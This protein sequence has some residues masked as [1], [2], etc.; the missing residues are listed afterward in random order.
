MN[1]PNDRI[2]IS[3][4]VVPDLDLMMDELR[5]VLTSGQL[6]NGR[7]V[8]R[9]EDLVREY[10]GSDLHVVAVSSNTSGMILSW[11]ALEVS[12]EVILPAFT[13]PATAHVIR[14]NGL[15]PVLADCDPETFNLDLA[16]VERVVTERT[17]GVAPVYIFGNAP[18]WDAFEPFLAERGLAAVSD[19]AHAFGTRVGSRPAGSFGS[20]EVFS[21]APT[22]VLTT[23]E[24]GLCITRDGDLADRLRRMRNYGN[25][26]DYDCREL[27]LN[28]RMTEI[29]ALLGVH[30]M[31]GHEAQVRHREQ[32]AALYRERL[33]EIPGI[34]FQRIAP[35]VRCTYNYFALL[36]DPDL[37]G[38]T[39]HTLH[40]LLGQVGIESKI[41][42]HPP[43]HEQR[44]Y[45]E[46]GEGRSFP[47][48]EWLVR[49][50]LCVPLTGHVGEAEL[51]RVVGAIRKA[52]ESANTRK[53]AW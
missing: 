9:F 27:G 5:D 32:M 30:G 17:V 33:A 29:H 24:G 48:T 49:R 28:A 26:G 10:V 23:G 25:P 18:D 46:L 12:G 16:D 3:R 4:P 52:H 31:P 14:W 50:I 2:Q 21:L 1:S 40:D 51:E 45:R 22:K 35:G 43:I 11:K 36:V 41:Y 20:V 7:H 44:L 6:T 53:A 8:R 38:M 42:F 19:A 39:N 15:T 37:F 13:F 34:S 47:N